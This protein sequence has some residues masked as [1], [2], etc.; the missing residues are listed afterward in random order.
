MEELAI[1]R[2]KRIAERSAAKGTRQEPLKVQA[3]ERKKN[4]SSTTEKTKLQAPTDENTTS[5]K[6]VMKSSTIDRL[7]TARTT[8]KKP[9]TTESKVGQTRKPTSKANSSMAPLSIKKAKENQE[10]KDK[11][12][13]LDK[14]IGSDNSRST[15]DVQGRDSRSATPVIS[16]DSRRT[17]RAQTER[18]D[19]N[20]DFGTDTVLHT[21]TSVEKRELATFSIKDASEEKISSRM[22]PDK[23]IL[24]L[25]DSSVPKEQQLN[26]DNRVRI[27]PDIAEH[28]HASERNLK[29]AVSNSN[30]KVAEKKKLSFSPEISVMNISTPPSDSE[31]ANTDLMHPRKK[32]SNGESSPKIPKGFRKLIFFGRRG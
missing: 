27:A 20:E 29:S 10:R 7:A 17:E 24:P 11:V 8:N 9:S 22:L 4:S 2:Q 3:K 12:K 19:R 32:W 1:Q 15:S 31:E 26:A 28:D 18:K 21:V 30:E 23:D 25:Q 6:P 13:P 14:K 5:R 16:E